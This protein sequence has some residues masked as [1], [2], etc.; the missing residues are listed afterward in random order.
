MNFVNIVLKHTPISKFHENPS[1]G[2]W[3]FR[4]D[5]WGERDMTKLIVDFAIL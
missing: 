1:C 5:R 4:A 3:V 2:S